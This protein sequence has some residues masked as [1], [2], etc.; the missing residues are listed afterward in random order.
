MASYTH[1]PKV[2]LREPCSTWVRP[3]RVPC[4]ANARILFCENLGFRSRENLVHLWPENDAK[5]ISPPKYPWLGFFWL[6]SSCVRS[7][8]A[9]CGRCSQT[10]I[11]HETNCPWGVSKDV[12]RI[13]ESPS[14][15]RILCIRFMF[16]GGD[17]FRRYSQR[18][19]ES[20]WIREC[21]PPQFR[22][23]K[24][25]AIFCSSKNMWSLESLEFEEHV[26][27]AQWTF[28]MARSPIVDSRSVVWQVSWAQLPWHLHRARHT[29]CSYSLHPR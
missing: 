8:R 15:R 4:S 6:R 29:H 10:P 26:V 7:A 14:S 17:N 5:N 20:H 3:T 23:G 25:C 16:R 13:N 24:L 12:T 28:A 1:V 9:S 22:V 2:N 19:L 27:I 18:L 11:S 21:W